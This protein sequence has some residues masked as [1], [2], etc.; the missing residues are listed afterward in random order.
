MPKGNGPEPGNGG[1][2]VVSLAALKGEIASLKVL[3]GEAPDE[4][5]EFALTQ[6]AK[7]FDIPKRKLRNWVDDVD[8]GARR[9]DR[10]IL[11]TTVEEANNR[12]DGLKKELVVEMADLPA[13]AAA[14]RD[15]FAATGYLF[16]RAQVIVK[17]VSPADG[18][19]PQ[20]VPLTVEGV[21]T[22]THRLR[23]PVKLTPGH[24]RSAFTLPDRVARLYL[25]KTVEWNLPQLVG[26]TTAPLLAKT[27]TYELLKGTTAKP[28]CGAATC[29]PSKFRSVHR[30]PKPRRPCR[31]SVHTSRPLCSPM[32]FAGATTPASSSSSSRS[33]RV[34]TK[35][36]FSPA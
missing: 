16:E 36:R 23:R 9:A 15:I 29:R 20:L 5:F 13:A 25:D 35:A 34:A 7:R 14:L 31:R 11:P 24:R 19:M 26:V 17:V 3:K 1:A 10:D 33:T 6:A 18:G 4:E 28:G 2:A 22:E 21:V 32:R 12:V 27:E 8:Q 30:R